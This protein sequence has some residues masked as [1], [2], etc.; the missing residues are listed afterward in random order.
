V[1]YLGLEG[2]RQGSATLSVL[3][4]A[5]FLMLTFST[6]ARADVTFCP[7]GSGAGQCRGPQG[8]GLNESTGN[9]Y[10]ADRNNNRIVVFT[11]TGGFVRAFGYGVAD[12]TTNALQTCS[13]IC[14][15]GIGGSGP[16][17]LDRPSRIA[18]DPTSGNVYVFD[19]G[20]FRVQKFSPEGTFLLQFG[21]HGSG[22]CEMESTSEPIAVGPEGIVYVADEKRVEKFSEAGAC[23]GE[24][25][26]LNPVSESSLA[27]REL[28]VDSSGNIYVSVAGAGGE[29]RK[30]SLAGALLYKLDPGSETSA[31]GVDPSDDVFAAQRQVRDQ[32]LGSFR[33]ITEYSSTGTTLRRFGYGKFSSNIP[34]VSPF[35][36]AT[37]DVYA[38]VEGAEVKYL[39][40][41][42]AGPI[43]P[44][45]SVEAPAA[46]ISNTKAALR[47][48]INPEGKTT[49]YHFEYVDQEGFQAQG[50]SFVGPATKSTAPGEV[51]ATDFNLH[52]V[53]ALAGCANP[54]TEAGSGTCLKPETVYHSRVVATNADGGDEGTVVGP[55]FETKPAID[56]AATFATE[57]GPETARLNAEVNPL[58]IPSTGYFEYVDDASFQVSGFDDALKVP[59]FDAEPPQ[60]GLDFGSGEAATLRGTTLYPLTP[61]TTYHYRV[62]VSD[63][64]IAPTRVEGPVSTFTTFTLPATEQCGANEVFRTGASEL[65]PDCRAYELVSPL[66]KESGDVIPLGEFTT[67]LPATLDQSSLAGSKL[68]YGSYRAYGDAEAG[69]FTSQ[70]VAER[71]AGGWRSHAITGPRG[72]LVADSLGT[73]DTELKVLSPDLCDAWLQ[74]VAEPPLATGAIPG[75]RNLYRRHDDG[76]CG[77]KSYEALTTATPPHQE[78]GKNLRLELQG[79]SADGT[80]SIYTAND[81]LPGT[82]APNN[83]SGKQQ[84]YERSGEILNYVCVLPGETPSTTAC[85]AGT[86]FGSIGGGQNRTASVDNAISA[87]G[88]RVFWTA[89]QSPSNGPGQIYVRIGGN[90]TIAVSK[91]GEEDSGTTQSIFLA[92]SRDGSRAFFLAGQDLYGFDVES[93]TTNLIAGEAA[94]I[95]GASED[96]SYLY[97]VSQE[98][99]SGPNGEAKSPV[100]GSPNLYLDHD[101]V[102]E[103]LA[104]LDPADA[105]QIPESGQTSA[106]SLVPFERNSRISADGRHAAFM[107]FANPTGY[108][109]TD[110]SS[111]KADAEVYRYA[112]DTEELLCVSCNPSGARPV[113][114]DIGAR[115]SG[116]KTF[117]A[118]GS[119]PGWENTLYASRALSEDGRRVFFEST[120]ALSPLDSNGV[121]DVYQWEGVGTGNC[122]QASSSYS[123]ANGGCVDLISS[124]QSAR[125]SRFVDASPSGED[126]FFS[127]LASLLPEDYGLVDIYDARVD[128]GL[129][130]PPLPAPECEAEACQ[131]PAPAPLLQTPS[132]LTYSGPGNVQEPAAKPKKCPKGKVK[133]NGHCVKKKA[134]KKGKGKKQ[135][136]AGR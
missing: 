125:L 123:A 4:L 31:I 22:A 124:G 92:A 17:Q 57:V 32:A 79:L 135:R 56:I 43:V 107:S 72:H 47:A 130:S 13:V 116:G 96:G 62:S 37:G 131:N 114:S 90:Q 64:L 28:G 24:V 106:I 29:L 109:N 60:G 103:F 88:Q 120:D 71:A 70:Y 45:I 27:I 40:F 66:E 26:I 19:S 122:T 52:G 7:Q 36:S 46:T 89:Y 49:T 16:G 93:E 112:A 81:N 34:G 84:L 104:T 102:F 110:A 5:V 133:K 30:Y 127:T 9:S 108:D 85:S 48:E 82:T 69:P 33:V 74:T 10:V 97:F 58:G 44:S 132:S 75:Y 113:G 101:G 12:G 11:P 77:E 25:P 128:G 14:F 115:L 129:P 83:S 73:L 2:L 76:S 1:K 86:A 65:L 87:D 8:V 94:G 117:W 59:D 23:D 105:V 42:P 38:S 99:L 18:V 15:S 98:A 119:I 53:Q 136:G 91:E 20:S 95:M 68:A 41:P 39:E 55:T 51:A 80:V 61:S 126:V 6:S 21:A 121:G 100:P 118:A 35:S 54:V 67:G 3:G 134:A 111:G 63:S 78:P 50:N